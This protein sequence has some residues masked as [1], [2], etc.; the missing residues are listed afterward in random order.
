M[1]DKKISSLHF[2][3]PQPVYHSDFFLLVENA[4]KA[5]IDWIQYRDKENDDD[6]FFKIAK[7]V[8]GLC[9][10]YKAVFIVNDNVEVAKQLDADGVHVG[11]QDLSV[12][13][14]RKILGNEKIIGQST[15]HLNQI[16]EAQKN[17]ADYIGFGPFQF[18]STRKNLNPIVG[19]TGYQLIFQDEMYQKNPLP[20]VAIGGIGTKE[21]IPLKK[22]GV[23]QFAVSSAISSAKNPTEEIKKLNDLIRS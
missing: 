6:L 2:L 15:N 22:A 9:E 16:I 12:L 13:E 5:G 11:Q 18:T 23:K 14:A 17:N 19:L 4:L 21:I 3:T 10:N 8:L 20:L 7:E 1:P